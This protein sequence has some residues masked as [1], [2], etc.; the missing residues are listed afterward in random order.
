M[1]VPPT[2]SR[3]WR[4]Q[5]RVL[6]AVAFA[7]HGLTAHAQPKDPPPAPRTRIELPTAERQAMEPVAQPQSPTP[8]SEEL[9]PTPDDARALP[10]ASDHQT[11]VEQVRLPNRTTEIRVTPALT[12]N[13]WTMTTREGRQPISPTA[14]SPGLSVPNLFTWE[15]GGTANAPA[16]SPPP[17][18]SSATPR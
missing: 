17:P 8:T 2:S 5:S 9:L 13:T 7:A 6:V 1:R 10:P 4:T 15:F 12:G 16:A 18:P 14:T 11:V 3:A